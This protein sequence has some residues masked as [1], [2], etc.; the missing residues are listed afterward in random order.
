M[1]TEASKEIV[2]EWGEVEYIMWGGMEDELQLERAN[3]IIRA[4]SKLQLV[5]AEDTRRI[6]G[7]VAVL[8]AICFG[9]FGTE[10]R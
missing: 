1:T 10:E 6:K 2:A 5:G 4:Q 3:A 9:Y 7:F 8:A